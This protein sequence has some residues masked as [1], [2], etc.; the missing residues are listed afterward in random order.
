MEYHVGVFAHNPDN[1][2]FCHSNSDFLESCQPALFHLLSMRPNG[3]REN[4]QPENGE[5]L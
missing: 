4:H 5:D 2:F 1:V 3:G